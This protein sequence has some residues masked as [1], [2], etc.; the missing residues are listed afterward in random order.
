MTQFALLF[1]DAPRSPPK[2]PGQLGSYGWANR[3]GLLGIAALPWVVLLSMKVNPLSW[4]TGVGYERLQFFHRQVS[5]ITIVIWA[6]HVGGELRT[7]PGVDEAYLRWGVAAIVAG[8]LLLVLGVRLIRT[9]IYE[10]FTYLH[11][12]MLVVILPALWYHIRPQSVFR[13]GVE[14]YLI[15]AMVFWAFDRISRMIQLLW[16]NGLWRFD[17]RCLEANLS[18]FGDRLVHVKLDKPCMGEWSPASHVYLASPPA[19]KTSWLIEAHPFTIATIPRKKV[20]AEVTESKDLSKLERGSS[21]SSELVKSSEDSDRMEFFIRPRSGFTKRLHK[22][23]KQRGRCELLVYGPFSAPRTFLYTYDTAILFA[24]GTGISWVLPQLL[25]AC[26]TADTG[27]VTLKTLIVV[28]TIKHV[29][30]LE[31]VR[32]HIVEVLKTSPV[33][34]Q[35]EIRVHVTQQTIREDDLP[36]EWRKEEK[37]KADLRQATP[38]LEQGRPIVD[39]IIDTHVC[40]A[41]GRVYV[42]VC[43]PQELAM[44][45]RRASR[46]VI[47]PLEVL[48]GKQNADVTVHVEL[49]GW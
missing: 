15:A 2:A 11:F 3:A 28:W 42:G 48:R 22:V 25:H 40:A 26:R 6:I 45:V 39:D 36:V 24:A 21:T 46:R 20:A 44:S 17:P 14:P 19:S 43:G 47:K 32:Q 7:R 13:V 16:L 31:V 1:A 49:Y 8:G 12:F 9:R 33:N 38:L 30:E 23:S 5:R 34:L 29:E 27:V 37:S 18:V 35:V 4:I 41:Q 10:F